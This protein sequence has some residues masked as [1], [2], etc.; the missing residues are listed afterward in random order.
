MLGTITITSPREGALDTMSRNVTRIDRAEIEAQQNTVGSTAELLARQVPGMATSS[1]T[2]TNFGQ[3]LRGRNALVLIDGVPMDTNRNVS[4]V[5]F[6]ISPS[7]IESIEVVHGG[8]AVYGDGAAGGIIYIN[9]VQASDAAME[10]ETTIGAA[11]S[12]SNIDDDALSGRITQKVTGRKDAFDY[13]FSVTGEQTQGFFDA[14]GD[15]IAPEQS[16]GDLSDTGTVDVLGK[17]GYEF[18]DQRLQFSFTYLN[19][20]QDTD[21][22]SDQSVNALPAGS[23]KARALKGLELAD[24]TNREN[25]TLNLDYSKDDLLGSRF[26]SQFYYRDYSTRFHPFDGRP[27]AGWNN[28]AQSFLESEVYGGRATFN[29]PV[30][31]L[32]A[33]GA[34]LIWGA[35]LKN[36]KTRMPVTVFDGGIFDAS[37]GNRFVVTD[38]ERTFMPELTTESY[39]VFGQLELFPTERLTLRAG[40]RHDWV[41]ASFDDYTTL[42]QGNVIQGGSIDYSETSF[43]AG[44]VFAATPNVDVYANY[45]QAFEL[46]DIGLQLRQAPAGFDVTDSNLDPRITDTYE[47]GTRGS[48]NNLSVGVAAFYSESDKGRVNVE[49]FTLVQDRTRE[50]IYGI[51]GS[52]DYTINERLGVGGTFTWQ[53]GE[54]IDPDTGARLAL[55]SYR[56]APL[57]LTGYVEYSP[58]PWWDLRLQALY[59]GT[60]DSAFDDGVGF[61][62]RKVDDYTVVDLYSSFDV[63]PGRLDVGIENLLNNQYHTVFG[64]LL[65]SGGN[66]SHIPA[67]GATLRAAYNVKW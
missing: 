20:E 11:T 5:L 62:G 65:R 18:G 60:R 14:D 42:G 35:D 4:R 31:A 50:E 41:E 15:R 10:F 34:N 66:S 30:D 36:E 46:P 57:K 19:A 8:S 26:D 59:S 45:A 63:G 32:A 48:W 33:H 9:T 52:V 23:V 12:L 61:G 27:F 29:T 47:I 24:Q 13:V 44:V 43:N 21:Y 28:L 64:Q 16:Q 58:R 25:L 2:L 51:E 39:G 40:V 22:V 1:Q 53:E 56:I 7:N 6:N 3:T 49:N 17:L 38:P 37:G 67:R 54:S 55:N